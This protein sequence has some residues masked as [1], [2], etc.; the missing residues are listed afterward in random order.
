MLDLQRSIGDAVFLVQSKIK[1]TGAIVKN[2]IRK[3]S[4][5]AVGEPNNIEHLFANLIS[6][7]CDALADRPEKIITLTVGAYVRDGQPFWKCSVAD[8]GC[9]IPK[10]Q[11][12]EI[13][14]PF[15][16][17]KEKG[18]GTGL[19]L[20]I[21]RGIVKDHRGEIKVES[22]Q[23]RGTIF[24]ILLPQANLGAVPDHDA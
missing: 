3:D 2:D 24:S 14:N 23:G 21:V 13:F 1:Q 5:Y 12:A 9:G 4:Y 19:G 10:E 20:S 11:M 18:K 8:T 22:E 7:A 17:T 16:T 6:N 15:F